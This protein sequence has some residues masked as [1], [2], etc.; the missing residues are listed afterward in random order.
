MTAS[1]LALLL[2]TQ[3]RAEWPT[4]RGPSGDG[5]APAGVEP[6]LEWSESK[7]VVW[8]TAIPGRGR[9]SPVILGDRVFVTFARETNIQRKKIGPDD[10]QMAD[11]VSLGAAGVDRQSGKILWERTLTEVDRPDPVHYLNSWATPTPALV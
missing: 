10:M 11:H 9:S 3:A 5:V 8:K 1:L 6:P 2:L 7:N 4:F